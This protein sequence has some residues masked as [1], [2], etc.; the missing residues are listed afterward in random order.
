MVLFKD[1]SV[2]SE[3][4][5]PLN[6]DSY[7][8]LTSVFDG[9][10]PDKEDESEQQITE[11]YTENNTPRKILPKIGLII[12]IILLATAWPISSKYLNKFRIY[13]TAIVAIITILYSLFLI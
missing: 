11:Q 1:I 13:I 7:E 6:S 4:T 12:L 10:I 2:S 8:A 5:A 3:D 9:E